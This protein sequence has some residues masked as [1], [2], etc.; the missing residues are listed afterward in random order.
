M[1]NGRTLR[2]MAG[3]AKLD[4]LTADLR[5]TGTKYNAALAVFYILYVLLDVPLN[6]LLKY[7]GGGRYLPL[8]A[9]AWGI[10]GTCV[11]AVKSYGGLVVC[12]LLLGAC[13]GGMFGG[14]ILYLSMFYKRHDLM[15]RLGVFYCGAPLSGAFGGLLATGLAKIK[16]HGYDGW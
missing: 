13:E 12:R 15:F 14:I 7:V 2:T 8:L 6:W 4:G 16:F 1:D 3:N 10:V 9:I 5:L 11:G